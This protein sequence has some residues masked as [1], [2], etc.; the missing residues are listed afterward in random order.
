MSGKNIYVAGPSSQIRDIEVYMAALRDAGWTI[1]FDWTAA[2]RNAGGIASPEDPKVR[3]DAALAD[4]DGV[5]KAQVLWLVQPDATSTSTGAWVEFGSALERRRVYKRVYKIIEEVGY[6]AHHDW[7]VPI[8]NVVIIASGSSRK[9]I[10][11][12]L[13]DVRFESHDDALEYILTS[14]LF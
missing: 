5:A 14:R 8:N 9:C 4:L 11:S 1:T 6:V 10:F 3:R 13:A 12:D 7:D 2:V